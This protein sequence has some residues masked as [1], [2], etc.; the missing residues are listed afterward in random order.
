MYKSLYSLK[1]WQ[2]TGYVLS[3]AAGGGDGDGDGGINENIYQDRHE[4][5]N[6]MI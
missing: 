1:F 5:Y 4:I 3:M 6:I 2:S